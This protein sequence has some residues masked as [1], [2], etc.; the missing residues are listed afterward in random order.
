MLKVSGF[1][2]KPLAKC[3]G[4]VDHKT[5]NLSVQWRL[6]VFKRGR[7]RSRGGACTFQWPCEL[8]C[9]H[10]SEMEP[11]RLMMMKGSP[12]NSSLMS[13]GDL[14]SVSEAPLAVVTETHRELMYHCSPEMESARFVVMERSPRDSSLMSVD[15][16]RISVCSP[17]GKRHKNSPFAGT[18]IQTHLSSQKWL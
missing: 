14:G 8:K 1:R 11:A 9:C 2:K 15:R 18:G 13:V 12:H 10:S 4:V 16:T 3:A 6:G 7:W 17:S 5:H